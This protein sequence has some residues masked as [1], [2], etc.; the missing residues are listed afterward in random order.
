[1][2]GVL[3]V[4]GAGGGAPGAVA[5]MLESRL[6]AWL[7]ARLLIT[8]CTATS[9]AGFGAPP[10]TAD[11]T[12]ESSALA[13]VWPTL[14]VASILADETELRMSSAA[15]WLSVDSTTPGAAD[16]TASTSD[17]AV[18]APSCES[19]AL[20]VPPASELSNCVCFS[21]VADSDRLSKTAATE[22]TAAVTSTLLRFMD[23]GVATTGAET[24][25]PEQGARPAAS[26]LLLSAETKAVESA[27]TAVMPDAM[28]VAADAEATDTVKAT[29]APEDIRRRRAT[30]V[31]P[32]T[33][34]AMRS[35]LSDVAMAELKPA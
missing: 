34:T 26:R 31:T 11:A 19:V 25:T 15:F 35:T 16:T 1:M 32:V 10:L 30:S 17:A 33:A 7:D 8:F 29:V 13:M 3:V 22:A 28:L 14:L 24:A 6:A 9:A 5:A 20:T 21:M 18:E 23:G 2:V 27:A 4:A 12:T